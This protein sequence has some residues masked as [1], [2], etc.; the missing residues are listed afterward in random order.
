MLRNEA[1]IG[2]GCFLS[3]DLPK[4]R[5]Q[6][7]KSAIH[8]PYWCR[9]VSIRG[10]S[11]MPSGEI[12]S[13][14]RDISVK[15]G[16]CCNC[17]I[18][19]F[20]FWSLFVCLEREVWLTLVSSGATSDFLLTPAALSSFF[21]EHTL[22]LGLDL[23]L[24]F[25]LVALF[26]A[27]LLCSKSA[28]FHQGPGWNPKQILPRPNKEMFNSLWKPITKNIRLSYLDVNILDVTYFRPKWDIL[29]ISCLSSLCH[30]L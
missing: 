18:E 22:S 6:F 24:S 7:G 2:Y 28:V 20:H 27:S 13:D 8:F 10:H 25:S 19:T 30:I 3:C 1:R 17:H 16:H 21:K 5:L 26:L 12:T 4:S 29:W 11:C 15:P 14:R 23:L 9:N